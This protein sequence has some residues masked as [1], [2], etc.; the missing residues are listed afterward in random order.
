MTA[1]LVPSA[2]VTSRSFFHTKTKTAAA[3]A[4][5]PGTIPAAL[6]QLGSLELL[7]LTDNLLSGEFDSNRG[8]ILD[9][10]LWQRIGTVAL[11]CCQGRFVPGFVL[12]VMVWKNVPA[13]G[14]NVRQHLQSES[15]RV[16]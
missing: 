9:G 5:T 11:M 7:R 10:V 16:K 1:A 12:R 13:F 6:G 15:A 2:F 8:L 14:N 3:H 4:D